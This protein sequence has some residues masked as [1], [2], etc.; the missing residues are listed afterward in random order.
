[1]DFDILKNLKDLNFN[2]VTLILG[3]YLIAIGVAYYFIFRKHHKKNKVELDELV[4]LVTKFYT[5]TMFSTLMIILGIACIINANSFKDTRRDVILWVLTG[6]LFVTGTI[7][8]YIFYI[9]RSLKDFDEEERTTTRK[10]NLKIGEILELIFLIIFMLMPIW[11]IPAFI[12]VIDERAELI[13]EL[14][15]AFVLSIASIVLLN[16][17]NPLDIKGKIKNIFTNKNKKLK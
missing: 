7:I 15:R 6:I 8:N 16:S 1:M 5:L 17:L 2:I 9:K 13:K 12:E 3:I 10:K 4:S 14:I 11:R